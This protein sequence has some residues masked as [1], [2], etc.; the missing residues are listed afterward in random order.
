MSAWPESHFR[1]E[2]HFR[3]S[4]EKIWSFVADTDLLN[5][6]SGL[7]TVAEHLAPEQRLSNARRRLR[8]RIYG[9]PLDY[10]E[11][12][13]EWVRPQRYGVRRRYLSGPLGDFRQL[14][15]LHP[16][17][18]DGTRLVYQ[19]WVRPRNLLGWVAIPFQ[20]GLLNRYLI[21]RAM[22][23][24]D[25]AA[26]RSQTR[27]DLPAFVNF[28]PGGEQRLKAL[29]DQL[30]ARGADAS[31]VGRL[32]ELIRRADDGSLAQM[33]PYA[34]ADRWAAPRRTVLELFLT[35]T[36]AGLLNFQWQV[37]C[38][39]CRGTKQTVETLSGVSRQ[40]HCST[41]NIDFKA[42]F[43]R[44]V[45]LTFKPNP[46]IREVYGDQY[47]VAGPQTRPHVISQQLLPPG[48][49]RELAVA[50]EGGRYRVRTLE[51]PGNQPAVVADD[52][53]AQA[54]LNIQS[55]GWLADELRLLPK[56]LIRLA[57]QTDR[58]QL[59]LL[60]RAA[61]SDQ[62]TTAADVTALQLFR[63]LFANEALRP[64]DEISVGSLTVLFTDLRGSTRLY[65]DIGDAPAFGLVMSHFDTLREAI[66][67][68][69]GAIV[70]T[71]G[72]AVMAI[73]RR[74]IAALK[75]VLRAQQM[76]AA[77]PDNLRPLWLKAGIHHGPAIA[78]TLNERLDYFGT[79]VNIA[80]RLVELSSGGDIVVSPTVHDDPEVAAWLSTP[81][82][83][84][85]VEPS[86]SALK[87]FDEEKFGL[88][89]V[90]AG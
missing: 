66:V 30:I 58:E 87:G 14:A 88:W 74:P 31:L 57:N 13:F 45:E 36:R 16:G 85:R 60:E 12:P 1:W 90:Q 10:E 81:G 23:R 73:F 84:L 55:A 35:A 39:S 43:E 67:A 42:N 51:L 37:L 79:T 4:P 63:D 44:Q 76:L 54:Q 69:D 18:Q 21:E 32:A 38:P 86:E 48:A 59:F 68:E 40:V 11:E 50:L 49:Q 7:P 9:V 65:R 56:P 22:R 27:L 34:L 78:V 83:L 2:W 19:V 62:A 75:A 61:W 72:D 80:A 46:A 8:L 6:D 41:C 77:P 82:N 20:I 52:G 28:A 47:C 89:R 33:R 29:A 15:E 25:E 3:S 5:R 24:Y 64:G 17:E 71:I 26:T 70:K 53:Q